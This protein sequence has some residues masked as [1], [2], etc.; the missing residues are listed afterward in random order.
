VILNPN[1][2]RVFHKVW[3]A[4]AFAANTPR[5]F[6]TTWLVRAT[7]RLGTYK[8]RVTVLRPDLRKR[9]HV[10]P[11]TAAVRVV[12]KPTAPPRPRNVLF[13]EDF[14][15]ATMTRFTN[16]FDWSVVDLNRD[17]DPWQGHHNEMC[18]GPETE[19]TLHHGPISNTNPGAEFW[20]CGPG[21]P[22][23]DH[24]MTSNGS[25]RTFGITAFSPKRSFANA[26]RVCWDVN[27]TESPGRRL[28]WEVQLLPAAAVANAPSLASQGLMVNGVDFERG[29]ARL[30]W[31]QGMDGTFMK[32]PWP[33]NAV[34]FD[35]TEELVR[36]WRGQTLAFSGGN[37]W[38]PGVRYVTQDRAKRAHHCM[39]DNGNGTITFRQERPGRATYVRTVQASFPA[40]FRVIFS[41]QNYNAGKDGTASNATW[42]WDNILV[43][44]AG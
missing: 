21:G 25:N 15:G 33:S 20:L 40:R 42:H 2:R 5:V 27:L 30:A 37:S 9:F 29:T 32:R 1:G 13:A 10:S 44:G 26:T 18:E 17:D 35:F 31:G 34:V 41:A 3:R 39:V 24:L 22:A 14:T 38:A 7:Q 12:A 43:E 36:I 11:P 23:T 6:K 16:R 8:V 19:R 28:W 4:R